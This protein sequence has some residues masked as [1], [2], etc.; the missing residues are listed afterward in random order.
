MDL[1]DITSMPLPV[2]APN[3]LRRVV[4]ITGATSGLG[5][6]FAWV[7]ANAGATVALTGRRVDRLEAL[8]AK[9]LEAGGAAKA[10]VLDVSRQSDVKRVAEMVEQQ[11]GVIDVLVNNA[12]V[13]SPATVTE[14]SAEDLELTMRI[15]AHGAFFMAQ[16]VGKRMITTG[17]SGQIIN[18]GSTGGQRPIAGFL[19]YCMSKA[20]MIMMTK[21]LAKE[22]APF[23]INVNVLCPG[24]TR[25]EINEQ[26][27]DTELGRAMVHSFPR[28]RVGEASDL[29]DILLLLSSGQLRLMTGAEITID[30]GQTL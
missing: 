18:I 8:Q 5:A 3:L 11:L 30:D 24:S 9:I 4:L 20:A 10:Y 2:S 13:A 14:Q 23:G 6:R 25:T 22:W 12:G 19:A 1:V 7:L 21:V 16:E 26:W 15:N 27:L 28:Q 17:R 29:D